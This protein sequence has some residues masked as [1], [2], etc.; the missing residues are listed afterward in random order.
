MLHH[1]KKM[2]FEKAKEL[3]DTI[4]SIR[5]LEESQIVRD[6]VDGDYN[7]INYIKKYDR[8]YI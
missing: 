6:F 3:K 8:F 4:I 1:A 7:I 5:S 2:E